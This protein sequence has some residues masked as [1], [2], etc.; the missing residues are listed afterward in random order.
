MK[1]TGMI[2]IP[3]P[4]K[5]TFFTSS[6]DGSRLYIDSKEVVDNEG[7]HPTAEKQGDIELEAGDHPITV[8]YFQAG[9]E[10]VLKVEWSGPGI[11]REEIPANVLFHA[12][13]RP[14]VPLETE[15]YAIDPQKAAIGGQM[16]A[17]MGCASCHLIPNVKS[18]RAATPLAD[19]DVESRTGCLGRTSDGG[20]PI[21]S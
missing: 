8:T 14:M 4:G 12:G 1:F 2:S 5:Y 15:D 18:V 6:D 19:L 11:T 3:R 9:G 20:F 10:W 16:F 7:V 13:A 17:A 21:T